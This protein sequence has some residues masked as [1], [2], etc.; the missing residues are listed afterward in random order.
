MKSLRV[1]FLG[2]AVAAF[3]TSMTLSGCGGGGDDDDCEDVCRH[4]YDLCVGG[5]PDE[6][7][8][9]E[10]VDECS[11]EASDEEKDCVSEASSCSE[12]LDCEDED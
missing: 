4:V 7:E 5:D 2:L 3:A 12:A 1:L 11:D 9:D 10:C 8:L 6:E